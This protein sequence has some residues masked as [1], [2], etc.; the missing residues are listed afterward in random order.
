[1]KVKLRLSIAMI[2]IMT[3]VVTVIVSI[4]LRRTSWISLDLNMMRVEFLAAQ[5]AEFWKGREDGYIRS[6]HTLAGVM[7]DFDSVPKWERRDR[8]GKML[9]SV[10]ESSEP[11]IVSLYMVWKPNAIDGMDERYIGKVG[12]GPAGQYA[13]TYTRETGLI[14]ARTSNDIEN[15][16]AHISGPNARK[17]RIDNPAPQNVNGKDTFTFRMSVPIISGGAN[18]VVGCVGCVLDIEIIQRVVENIVK[19]NDIIDMAA[20]YSGNGT[21]LA[22]LKPE[23]IG[24]KIFD[25]DVELGDSVAVIFSAIQNGTTFSDTKYAPALHENIGFVIKPFQI[26]NSDQKLAILI[27]ASEANI[28]N[29]VRDITRYIV[30][31]AALALTL[32]AIIVYFVLNNVT[33]PIIR[34][35]KT[36]KVIPLEKHNQGG[37]QSGSVSKTA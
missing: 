6:L 24:K 2:A 1:M 7:S 14:K 37:K 9:K 20:V 26:G 15:I 12:A 10:L 22:H 5:Q 16:M 23:R 28:F 29:E 11:D 34:M 19:T 13:I 27:G 33:K 3:V 4:L 25:V 36:L 8:Y 32:S 17:D 35:T 30:I 18:E 21:I 31:L